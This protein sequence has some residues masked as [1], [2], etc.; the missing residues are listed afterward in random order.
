MISLVLTVIKP[1]NYNGSYKRLI[2]QMASVS[3]RRAAP[4]Y[5]ALTLFVPNSPHKRPVTPKNLSKKQSSVWWFETSWHPCDVIVVLWGFHPHRKPRAAVWSILSSPTT[6]ET[7][8]ANVGIMTN[9]L[10]FRCSVWYRC[11]HGF[12]EFRDDVIKWKHFPRYWPFVRGI[13]RSPVNCP[14]KVQR[15]EALM[16]F[17]ICVWINGGVNNRETG[18]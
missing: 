16:F 8:D 12:P 17:F 13:Q 14:H 7:S 4:N 1:V 9:L 5:F 6:L 2:N 11:A 15:R 10:G 3:Q 18:D